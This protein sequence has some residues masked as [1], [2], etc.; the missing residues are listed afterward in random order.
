MQLKTLTQVNSKAKYTFDP[1]DIGL[2]HQEIQTR[3]AHVISIW[4]SI[5]GLT[6]SIVL[7]A[8]GA[9]V[10]VAAAMYSAITSAPASNAALKTAV[11]LGLKPKYAELFNAI[12]TISGE[13]GEHRHRLAHWY[14]GY[15]SDIPNALL[16]LNPKDGF[17]RGAENMTYWH[18]GEH[19]KYTP[20]QLSKIRVASKE[21]MDTLIAELLSHLDRVTHFLELLRL[22][23]T[24]DVARAVIRRQYDR[25]YNEHRIHQILILARADR[26]S[27]KATQRR[28]S[29]A[30]ARRHG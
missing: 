8:L 17:L 1:R 10:K 3:I 24:A 6:A 29:R 27:K 25:L 18:T 20:R 4:S 13:L 7:W 19:E 12:W 22:S 23:L 16:L 28:R 9:D 11:R 2:K 21:Y 26:K 5:E 14:V 30:K 15:S